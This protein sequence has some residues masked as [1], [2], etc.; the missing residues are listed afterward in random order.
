VTL[1]VLAASV[2]AWLPLTLSA[3]QP[4]VTSHPHRVMAV[5]ARTEPPLTVPIPVPPP[6]AQA[7]AAGP[8]VPIPAATPSPS[9]T[10]T[11]SPVI[12]A[13]TELSGSP[14]QIAEAMLSSFGW[15]ASQMGCLL[16]LWQHE[17]A[18]SVTAENPSGAYGIPQALPGDKMASAG[19]DWQTDP[20][21]QV[22]W[23]EEYIDSVYG[24]PCGAWTHEEADGWY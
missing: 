17:S 23:G 19:A 5:A 8:V 10:P 21:T 12:A 14:Q 13:A 22:K 24:S 15:D 6:A 4:H 1:A 20:A 16:P 9:P 11:P 2:S 7:T 3:P 18:W